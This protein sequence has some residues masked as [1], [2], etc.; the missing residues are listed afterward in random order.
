MIQFIVILLGLI[1]PNKATNTTVSNGT[2]VTTQNS[3]TNASEVV[4]DT[5]G[6]TGQILP[7]KK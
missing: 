6:E 2:I 7:P 5:S 3:F 4:E 1:F